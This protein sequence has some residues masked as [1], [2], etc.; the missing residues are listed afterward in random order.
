MYVDLYSTLIARRVLKR[1]TPTHAQDI[2]YTTVTL[3]P[4]VVRAFASQA[5]GWILVTAPL[6]NAR[7]QE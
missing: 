6:P 2:V 5:E 7:Q 3:A 4:V 1:A